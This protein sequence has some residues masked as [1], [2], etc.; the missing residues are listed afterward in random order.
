MLASTL[1]L[2][3]APQVTSVPLESQFDED[4]GPASYAASFAPG[5]GTWFL[6]HSSPSLVA[7]D[8]AT[9]SATASTPLDDAVY[10]SG[11]TPDGAT[12]ILQRPFGRIT[13]HTVPGLAEIA[14]A[15]HPASGTG[16]S[17]FVMNRASTQALVVARNG[18]VDVVD[19]A[20][21][22]RLQW[23]SSPGSITD[24]GGLKSGLAA[25]DRTFVSAG[26]L[27]IKA[28]DS[29]TGQL[30]TSV[31]FGANREA[32]QIVV[33]SAGT[34]AYVLVQDATSGA[35]RVDVDVFDLPSLNLVSSTP[36]TI[37]GHELVGGVEFTLSGNGVRGVIAQ[38]N[39]AYLIEL[40]TGAATQLADYDV[41]GASVSVDGTTAAAVTGAELLLFDAAT[42]VQQAS[43]LLQY[44]L[45]FGGI[46]TRHPFRPLFMAVNGSDRLEI[47]ERMPSGT[48]TFQDVNSGF[49]DQEDGASEPLE[50]QDGRY[51]AVLHAGSDELT[52]VD[53]DSESVVGRV[54]LERE[55]LAMD[56]LPSGEVAVVHGR[57]AS[58][59]VVD[60]GAL[61]TVRRVDLM[62]RGTAVAAV[63]GSTTVWAHVME[64][65]LRGLELIDL[66]NG[67][68]LATVAL[69]AP[70]RT[71]ALQPDVVFDFTNDLAFTV[72]AGAGEVTVVD[73]AA[74]AVVGSASFTAGQAAQ[75]FPALDGSRVTVLSS[76]AEVSSWRLTPSGLVPDWSYSCVAQP[77]GRETAANGQLSL[78]GTR[79]IV[80]MPN[81]YYPPPAGTCPKSVTLDA[82][83]G[84]VVFTSDLNTA[85]THGQQV[86]GGNERIRMGTSSSIWQWRFDGL[87]FVPGH[88]IQTP[89]QFAW[90]DVSRGSL[91]GRTYGVALELSTSLDVL[92][93][94]DPLD[95][96]RQFACHP[97]VPNLTGV[98]ATLE[99]EGGGLATGRLAARVTDLQPNGMFGYLLVADTL[100]APMPAAGSQGLLCLGGNL[101]RYVD[102]VQR[103]DAG[104]QQRYHI[105]LNS[106]PMS[107]GSTAAQPGET[108]SF[109]SWYRD[110]DA[111][112]QPTSNFSSAVAVEI[113]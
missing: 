76:N 66:S 99:I 91:S 51:V 21:G 67:A 49:G 24:Y 4:D 86:D 17:H 37:V 59:T 25:D 68:N 111:L 35:M 62:G 2:A 94:V 7:M 32:K 71:V 23:F 103:A 34:L 105:D 85:W 79:V 65:G 101:G 89:G 58:I 110:L 100:T 39:G 44:P 31:A 42:G 33:N 13:I 96:R 14:E 28:F 55:P 53:V 8:M 106:L 40:A 47:V 60:P 83:T 90:G 113:R 22:A 107:I 50:L 1:L 12:M 43:R 18:H 102:Q 30:V 61:A 16:T 87:E 11:I 97:A 72:D 29:V 74:R 57:G 82:A 95:G 36:T 69:P 70:S 56:V 54:D 77:V 104:G 92:A 109:Q 78:D 20:T 10:L 5:G 38:Y 19:L 3:L 64:P 80:S 63:P 98:A 15:D 27:R 93:I 112:G 26:R 108:W 88:L 9:L 81:G 73:L 84:Q 48:F 75:A 41:K 52:L 45:S 6:P 46:L